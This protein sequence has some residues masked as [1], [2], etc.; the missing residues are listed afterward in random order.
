MNLR[1]FIADY[2]YLK[3]P[4]FSAFL[5]YFWGYIISYNKSYSLYGEDLLLEDVFKDIG[6]IKNGTYLDIGAFHPKWI[7]NTYKLSKIGWRGFVVDIDS[8]KLWGFKFRKNCWIKCGAA[9]QSSYQQDTITIYKFRRMHSEWDTIN[10]NEAEK[11]REKYGVEFDICEIP[12]IRINELLSEVCLTLGATLDYLNIDI[13]GAD[14]DL[15][16]SVKLKDYGVSVLSFENN[17]FFPG[18]SELCDYLTQQGYVHLATLGGTH[19]YVDR[20]ILKQRFRKLY[21]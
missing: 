16:L 3:S 6:H 2:I 4:K 15:I 17:S 5:S 11:T 8:Q 21:K 13:E 19:T 20:K 7:S 9:V 1:R 14:E 18:S 12:A 10:L